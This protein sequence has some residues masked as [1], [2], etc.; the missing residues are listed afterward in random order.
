M[1]QGCFLLRRVELVMLAGGFKEAWIGN[2]CKQHLPDTCWV[3][4][5]VLNLRWHCLIIPLWALNGDDVLVLL[6]AEQLHKL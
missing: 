6:N 5:I 4:G 1:T 2:L 3:P